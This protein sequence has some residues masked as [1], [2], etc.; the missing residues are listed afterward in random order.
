MCDQDGLVTGVELLDFVQREVALATDE[1][2]HPS[3]QEAG[4][5]P[6]FPLAA[7]PEQL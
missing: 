7:D 6:A 4:F 3:Y 1:Q 5:N 2:Q